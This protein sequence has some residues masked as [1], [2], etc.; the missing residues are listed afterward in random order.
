MKKAL[1]G[2]KSDRTRLLRLLAPIKDSSFVI[3]FA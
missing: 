1:R 2:L 3:S